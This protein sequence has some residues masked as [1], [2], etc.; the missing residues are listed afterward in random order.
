M[1]ALN[2]LCDI[3]PFEKYDHRLAC[4][5]AKTVRICP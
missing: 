4:P 3:R 2:V 5:P 1:T